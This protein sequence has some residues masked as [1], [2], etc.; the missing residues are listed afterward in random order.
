M[1]V[2]LVRAG[3]EERDRL[4]PGA[5]AEGVDGVRPDF[6]PVTPDVLLPGQAVALEVEQQLAGGGDV[7]VPLVDPLAADAAGP[8]AHDEDAG[9]VGV[10]PR[11]VDPL[12]F[13]HLFL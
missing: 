1:A 4:V 13:H 8:E 11:V 10:F 12:D 9:A 7:T 2:M 6:L 5:A 3:A